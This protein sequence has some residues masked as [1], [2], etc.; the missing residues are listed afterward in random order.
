MYVY[1]PSHNYLQQQA[2]LQQVPLVLAF[3]FRFLFTRFYFCNHFECVSIASKLAGNT[4]KWPDSKK[5]ANKL[6]TLW[7]GQ[8]GVFFSYTYFLIAAHNAIKL[9][10]FTCNLCANTCVCFVFSRCLPKSF[11]FGPAVTNVITIIAQ[12]FQKCKCN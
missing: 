1:L 9:A 11:V 8:V 7:L 3:Q 12:V 10:Y 5:K 6:S 2:T 4:K